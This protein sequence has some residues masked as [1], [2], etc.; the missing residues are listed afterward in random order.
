MQP[1]PIAETS[2]PS[3]SESACLHGTIL[4]QWR[5]IVGRDVFPLNL[6]NVLTV[7]RIMLVP[8]LVVALLGNTP[9]GDVFAAIVFAV[10]SLTDFVD[11]YL[12]RAAG[13]VTTF[14]KL[15]DPL[16]DKLLIIAALVALVSLHRLAAWVA[17]VIIARE[18]AV[19]VLRIGATQAGRGDRRE[20]AR[21]AEDL[22]ADRRDPRP[23]RR[24]GKPLWV[25]ALLY[26]A[27]VVTVLSG[28]D[29]FF[30][31]APAAGSSAG[32]R[33]RPSGWR[34]GRGAGAGASAGVEPLLERRLARRGRARRRSPRAARR[35]FRGARRRRCAGG[36]SRGSPGAPTRSS[37]RRARGNA[38]DDAGDHLAHAV[39]DE[40][41]AAVRLLDDLDLVAALHQL[42]DLRRHARLDD[43]QQRGR[44]DLL[45]AVLGQPMCSV[46]R[47]RWLC[48]ATGTRSRTRSISSLGEVI[49]GEALARPAGDELLRAR[50]RRHAGGRHADH[51]ARAVLGGDRRPSSV[52]ISWVLIPD[53]GAGLCSG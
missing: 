46:A 52:Y 5:D 44:V 18:F 47:P 14:G 19:T 35:A 31:A 49:G 48:V 38:R 28:L 10:A 34:A 6:P 41:R 1:R 15:M 13:S 27:V 43:R 36:S 50:A 33:R 37:R 12:A 20:P 4:S 32:A 23:H 51:A 2:G 24:A 30:G 29:F 21:Q 11:G 40:A 26:A 53:T 16:A 9:D 45:V 42:V 39:L 8:V 7:L 17:M 25:T 3:G 22:R